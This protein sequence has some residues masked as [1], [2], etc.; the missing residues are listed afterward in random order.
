MLM[1]KVDGKAEKSQQSRKN[2]GEHKNI[3]KGK[4]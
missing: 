1:H 3:L 2:Y 4:D